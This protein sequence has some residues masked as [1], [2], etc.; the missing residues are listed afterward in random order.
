MTKKDETG[1][2]TLE[3]LKWVEKHGGL[4]F[5]I[6]T[7]G[8]EHMTMSM[9]TRLITMLAEKSYYEIIFVLLMVHREVPFVQSLYKS[10]LLDYVISEWE[11]GRKEKLIKSVLKELE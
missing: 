4:W 11:S 7:P 6:C 3:F 8:D 5:L 10:M 9:M 1:G 2:R